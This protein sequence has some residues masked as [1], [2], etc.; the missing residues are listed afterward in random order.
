M[1]LATYLHKINLYDQI[2]NGIKK[3]FGPNQDLFCMAVTR[4]EDCEFK[5]MNRS[6]QIAGTCQGTRLIRL[7]EKVAERPADRNNTILHEVGHL[8]RNCER[9]FYGESRFESMGRIRKRRSI[10]G[11]EWKSIVISIGGSAET[12]HNYDY[13]KGNP[14][15][16]KHKYTCKDCGYEHFTHRRLKNMDVRYHRGCRRKPNGGHFTH[17]QLR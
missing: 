12:C 7:H 8:I 14:S 5:I 6:K 2:I 16:Y 3:Y 4:I 15:E 13:L 17:T 9:K 10:H 1:K 11:R